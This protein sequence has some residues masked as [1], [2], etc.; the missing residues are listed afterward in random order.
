M[1][2]EMSTVRTTIALDSEVKKESSSVLNELGL[3]L[4]SYV[5]MALRQLIRDRQLPFTPSLRSKAAD[6]DY[7]LALLAQERL[8]DPNTKFLTH[9]EV[10]GEED[11]PFT[12]EE[13]DSVELDY[14][15]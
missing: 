11:F 1:R 15:D 14:D 7:A 5:N 6:E 4:N 2:C 9:E 12:Q 13:L 10:F 8:T 3:T